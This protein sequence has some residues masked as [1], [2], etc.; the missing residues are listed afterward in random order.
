MWISADA[1]NKYGPS[2]WDCWPTQYVDVGRLNEQPWARPIIRS[3]TTIGPHSEESWV[4]LM[5]LSADHICGR[6]P[7]Q[8]TTMGLADDEVY[9]YHR[10]IQWRV[11]GSAHVIVGR[12]NILMLADTINKHG[13]CPYSGRPSTESA[14]TIGP[15]SKELWALPMSLLAN[16]INKY[17]PYPYSGRPSTESATTIGPHSKQLWAQPMSLL[18][19]IAYWVG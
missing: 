14:T 2:L 17:G 1:M 10:P 11:M 16:A 9:N 15:H 7:T 5:S 6:R 12:P 13:P 4:L 8:W 18:A 3:A 19:H